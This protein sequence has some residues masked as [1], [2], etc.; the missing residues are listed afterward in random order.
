MFCILCIDI[1]IAPPDWGRS[2][3]S[4]LVARALVPLPNS[5]TVGVHPEAAEF[6]IP[7]RHHL[8]GAQTGPRVVGTSWYCWLVTGCIGFESTARNATETATLHH[9]I[10]TH[11]CQA[12]Q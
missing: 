11:A 7:H 3:L 2:R 8:L 12:E 1:A 5:V 6:E 10:G 9:R 4:A